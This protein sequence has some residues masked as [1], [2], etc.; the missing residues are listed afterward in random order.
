MGHRNSITAERAAEGLQCILR[1]QALHILS[2]RVWSPISCCPY[3]VV[4]SPLLVAV[5]RLI[6]DGCCLPPGGVVAELRLE[7]A[8]DVFAM[9]FAELDIHLGEI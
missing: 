2:S 4:C 3:C 1:L 9:D 8:T 6:A 7:L 5:W